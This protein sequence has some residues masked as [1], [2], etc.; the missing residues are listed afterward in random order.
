MKLC[1]SLYYA[2]CVVFILL[3]YGAVVPFLLSSGIV[4]LMVLGSLAMFVPVVYL[5]V[6]FFKGENK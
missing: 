3:F 2:L 4:Y 6:L 5:I 1:Y